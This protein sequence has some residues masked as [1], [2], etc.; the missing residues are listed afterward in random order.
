MNGRK[1]SSRGE[2]AATEAATGAIA[3]NPVTAGP[4]VILASEIIGP[5]HMGTNPAREW[6]GE[7]ARPGAPV[8]EQVDAGCDAFWRERARHQSGIAGNV[9]C[10]TEADPTMKQSARRR[11]ADPAGA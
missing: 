7:V 3:R 8:S 2:I 11:K 10:A 6:P 5:W 1:R 9:T 4:L